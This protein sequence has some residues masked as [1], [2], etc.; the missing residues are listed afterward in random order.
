MS[1]CLSGPGETGPRSGGASSA[2][3][4]GRT[5]RIGIAAGLAGLILLVQPACLFRKHKTGAPVVLPSPVRIAYLPLN[6]PDASPD[7]RW[8]S[9]AVPVMM[10]KVGEKAPD[11]EAVPLWETMPV[12]V[13]ASG[14]SRT[15]TPEVAAYVASRLSAK[16]ATQ[17]E[18]SPTKGGVQMTMD[19]IP[20]KTTLVPY[21][22]QRELSVDS[23][24]SH[25]RDALGQFLT[26]LVLRPMAKGD[27]ASIDAATL[28]QVAEALDR[29][30]GWFV[31]ADPGK[32]DKVVADL[33]RSDRGLARLLF[34]PNL[35]PVVGTPLTAPKAGQ[36]S[37]PSPAPAAKPEVAPQGSQSQAP[38][39]TSSD[40]AGRPPQAAAAAQGPAPPV[41]A[42]SKPGAPPAE[43]GVS[44][45]TGSSPPPESLPQRLDTGAALPARERGGAAI[46]SPGF[47]PASTP[48]EASQSRTRP[49][50]E[51]P[52][53]A[54][55]EKNVPQIM[56]KA[57]PTSR[58]A[59]FKIQVGSSPNREDSVK[60]AQ[61]L[62]A[63]GIAAEIE[64]AN[65]KERG[66][67]Y[68]VRLAGYSSRKAAEAAG[69][70]LV[71][72]G[73]IKEFWLVP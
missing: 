46:S 2:R 35:Y 56:N 66:V 17:G 11:L 53:F 36:P 28:K 48:A 69:R 20:A 70:K 3:V 25:F 27:G 15:I 34:N 60:M 71:A 39:P 5:A 14:N 26:Y 59:G 31:A 37:T 10:A 19:F 42:S 54:P 47:L 68:R 51:S 43:A 30:Y 8:L 62:T 32:S 21:R 13:E 58:G 9:L 24:A 16:W 49:A 41:S 63:A 67:W 4:S 55:G 1:K 50:G 7:S 18:L 45:P 23:M 33:A 44:P 6:S 61:R 22:Y 38:V 29:E 65:L 12:A 52:R 57:S 64:T 40:N 72:D 73:V